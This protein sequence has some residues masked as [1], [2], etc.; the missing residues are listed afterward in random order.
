MS[1]FEIAQMYDFSNNPYNK[2][3]EAML[4]TLFF[5]QAWKSLDRS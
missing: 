3:S 5:L 2:V 1:K 4:C